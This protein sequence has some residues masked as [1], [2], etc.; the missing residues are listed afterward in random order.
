MNHLDTKTNTVK[1][2]KLSLSFSKDNYV[3]NILQM[4]LEMFSELKKIT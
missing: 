2:A 4:L 3:V 1:N